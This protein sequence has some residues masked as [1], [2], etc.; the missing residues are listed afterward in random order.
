M[1]KRKKIK[2]TNEHIGKIKIVD[3]FLPKPEDLV[4]KEETVKITLS[5]TKSSVNFFK[6]EATKYRANYQAMIRALIDQ[7]A[8]HFLHDNLGSN[9]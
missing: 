7:Y 9:Y 1:K 6:H 4:L 2:Y 8:S 3:D 5:L